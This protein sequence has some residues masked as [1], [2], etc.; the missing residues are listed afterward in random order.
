MKRSSG[1]FLQNIGGQDLLVPL[2]AKVMDLNGV[3]VLNAT[4]RFIWELLAQDR[5][6]DDLA[7]A[8]GEHFDVEPERA[9]IDIQAFVAE[10][11]K[12]GGVET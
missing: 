5:S 2:G 8:V 1:F 11:A 7:A 9:R 12:W 6:L 10:I 3:I 4:G